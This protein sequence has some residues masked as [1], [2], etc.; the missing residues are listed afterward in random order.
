MRLLIDTTPLRGDRT[1]RRLWVGTTLSAFGG[2]LT[3][4]AVL[5]QVWQLTGSTAWVGALGLAQ[6]LPRVV[7]GLVGG[8]LADRLDRRRL[9]LVATTAL[10]VVGALLAGQALVGPQQLWVVFVLVAV[11]AGAAAL[12]GPARRSFTARLLP[13]EQVPAGIALD[14]AAFQAAMLVGPALGGL[15]IGGAG[16]GACYLLDLATFGAAL[17][18]VAGLPA[19]PS[20][21]DATRRRG[22]VR[23]GWRYVV[24]RPTLRGALVTDLVATVL[25]MPISLYPAIN[26]ERFGGRPQTLGLFLSVIA[27]G[28]VIQLVTDDDHR[29]RVSSLELV[30]GAAGPDVGNL[31]GGLVAGVTS[32]AFA[33]VSGALACLAGIAFVTVTSTSLRRFMVRADR[34]GGPHGAASAALAVQ[35]PA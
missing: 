5:Y 11:H 31:R 3:I 20:A 2:Q 19:L 29:G 17:I 33:V 21:G 32:P 22:L 1:W 7:F 8:G 18:G 16:V 30:V 10:I 12:G 6:A 27:R 4:V 23:A 26:A 15:V 13:R 14:H 9:V 34:D 35:S 28:A 25:A 24:H